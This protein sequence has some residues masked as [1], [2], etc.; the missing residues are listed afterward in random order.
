MVGDVLHDV[1]LGSGLFF[2]VLCGFDALLT[3]L[4]VVGS[5]SPVNADGGV[6]AVSLLAFIANWWCSALVLIIHVVVVSCA[7][8]IV[9]VVSAPTIY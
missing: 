6:F 3:S 5:V 8:D 4:I 1:G 2:D 9:A 7:L